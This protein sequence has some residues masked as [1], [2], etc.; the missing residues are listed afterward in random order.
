[1]EHYDSQMAQRVWDRV[2]QEPGEAKPGIGSM[3]MGEAQIAGTLGLLQHRYPQLRPVLDQTRRR[4]QCLQ[5]IR[6]LA[7]GSS[8]APAAL[9][10]SG[11]AAGSAL[12]RCLSQ[13]LKSALGYQSRSG[14]PEYGFC[15]ADMAQEVYRGCRVILE[16]LGGAAQQHTG[17]G[18]HS[19][20]KPSKYF[21]QNE[22]AT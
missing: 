11:E 3:L 7:E 17:E 15:Y 10:H 20:Q 16:L 6:F 9:K 14:D 18:G 2:R 1:M 4:I 19:K 5:G 12:R 21:T 22:R 13:M 8:P